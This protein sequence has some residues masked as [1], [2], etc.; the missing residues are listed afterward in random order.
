MISED[1]ITYAGLDSGAKIIENPLIMDNLELTPSIELFL[2]CAEKG[3]PII[4]LGEGNPHIAITAGVHGDELPPQIA[5]IRLLEHLQ[6]KKLKGTLYLIP[7]T[8]PMAT[9]A[10]TRRE[11]VLDL[12]R[13]SLIPH[14]LT[15]NI[16]EL[17]KESDVI[18]LADFH[19]T[20]PQTHPGTES[21]FCSLKP[22]KESKKIAEYITIRMDSQLIEY[23]N[24]ASLY[25]GALE[26][27]VNKIGVPSITCEVVSIP[28][29]INKGS[30]DRSFEQMICFLEYFNLLY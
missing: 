14:T 24:A 26:D 11:G 19:S 28:G 30:V 12:N 17:I 25:K 22:N 2:K 6:G 1:N 27:E 5:A 21:I 3:T 29:K 16:L 10:N 7:I 4:K 18:A 23:T 15:N 8:S 13:S 9:H 20:G